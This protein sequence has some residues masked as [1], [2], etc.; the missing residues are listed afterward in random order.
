MKFAVV[1]GAIY[2]KGA[3]MADEKKEPPLE[4][5]IIKHETP[6]NFTETKHPEETVQLLEKAFAQLFNIEQA[7]EYAGISHTT[8]HNWINDDPIFE[9]RMKYAKNE[10][11]RS[12]K[13]LVARGLAT[14]DV[15]VAR[16]LLE[17]KDPEFKNRAVIEPPEDLG[18]DR[19]KIREFL[20]DDGRDDVSEQPA[21][22]DGAE[23]G[24]EVPPT[25]PDLS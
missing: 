22:A 24:E 2:G 6:I 19:R 4:G 11:L 16:W 21:T 18:K 7:C 20:D 12:A 8:Y 23:A 17:R 5:E 1:A 9:Q 14:G 13:S 25:P 15:G 3:I 10:P